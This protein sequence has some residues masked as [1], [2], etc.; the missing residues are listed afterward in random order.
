MEQYMWIIWLSA[1]V[2]F[3]IIE[4]IGTDL[5]TIWFA[6]GALIATIVS[7]IPNVPWW[8][9]VIVF[10]VISVATLFALRPLTRK[11]MRGK[12]VQ[13][14]ADSLVGRRGMLLED[15]GPFQRG[16]V[17]IGDVKWTALGIEDDSK[18]EAG[19]VV[20]IVAISGNKLIVRPVEKTAE[21][22]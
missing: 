18:I 20:E 5:V 4:A 3:L 19:Q 16:T 17:Q 12:I 9:E 7:F 21:G 11:Y 15:I 10:L 2:I 22:E 1:F 8:V 14:N 6:L 13:S